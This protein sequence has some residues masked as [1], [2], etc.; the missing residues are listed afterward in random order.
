MASQSINIAFPFKN[1]VNGGVFAT[2][3][4][5]ESALK[6]DLIALLTLRRGQRPMQGNMYSPVYDYIMEPLDDST[7]ENLKKDITTKVNE[8]LPQLTIVSLTATPQTA[9]GQPNYLILN[10]KFSVNQLFGAVQN[11]TLNYPINN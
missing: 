6:A 8:Y 1:S 10:I 3:N 11:L 2:N 9:S 7:I 4:T 5:T